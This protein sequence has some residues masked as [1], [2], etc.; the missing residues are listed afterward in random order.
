MISNYVKQNS[1]NHPSTSVQDIF[2]LIYQASFGRE[3]MVSEDMKGYLDREWELVEAEDIP[4]YEDISDD[5]MRVS[6]ASWKNRGLKKDWLWKLF[7]FDKEF[8]AGCSFE[9]N[10]S[11]VRN[12]IENGIIDIPLK[13][14]DEFSE[15]Y[16]ALGVRPLHHSERYRREER[17]HY[18]VLPSCYK[19]AIEILYRISDE[20]KV[21]AIDGRAAS[22]KTTV[23]GILSHVLNTNPVRMDDFFLPKELR[24]KERLEEAGGNIHYE[25]FIEEVLSD[26]RSE[27]A[28]SY[29]VFDCSKMGINGKREIPE[30]DIRIVEGSYSH[31]PIFGSYADL[32]VFSDVDPEEQIRRIKVRNGDEMAKI[33]SSKWI[34]MEERYFDTYSVRENSD[35]II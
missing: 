3:H 22:G 16:M 10:L 20:V 17:P 12:A 30:G 2:K 21:I 23:A 11:E 4:L 33:F 24:Y 27:K 34:L 8:G 31:H 18:R 26:I 14:W 28:F 35:I 32:R 7:S 25:R 1:L 5:Y 19:R 29:N 6:I 15:K 13:E 9:E